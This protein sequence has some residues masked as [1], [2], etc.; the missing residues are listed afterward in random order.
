MRKYYEAPSLPT[1]CKSKNFVASI[2]VYY[3]SCVCSRY[4]HPTQVGY[5]GVGHVSVWY[6]VFLKAEVDVQITV[7]IRLQRVRENALQTLFR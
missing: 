5:I 1:R 2:S 4:T 7:K 6:R 3:E